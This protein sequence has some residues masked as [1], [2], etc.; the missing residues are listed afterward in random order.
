MSGGQMVFSSDV[1]LPS[2]AQQVVK[3]LRSYQ[4]TFNLDSAVKRPEVC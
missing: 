3:P 2:A 4:Y 1:V